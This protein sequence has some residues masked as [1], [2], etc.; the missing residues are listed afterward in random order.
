MRSVA[1]GPALAS[2]AIAVAEQVPAAPEPSLPAGLGARLGRGTALRQILRGLAGGAVLQVGNKLLALASSVVLARLLGVEGFGLFAF[3]VAAGGLLSVVIEW[4]QGPLILRETARAAGDESSGRDERHLPQSIALLCT[5]AAAVVAVLAAALALSDLGLSPLE[6]WALAIAAPLGLFTA[7]VRVLAAS[8]VGARRLL[9]GQAVEQL[10][11]PAVLVAGA[12][13]LSSLQIGSAFLAMGLQTS[14]MIVAVACGIVALRAEIF[15]T[16]ARRP[17]LGLIAR[18]GWPFL[19]IGSALFISQQ[20]D[21]LIIGFVLGTEDVA[22][23]RIG[24]QLAATAIFPT[25]L[26]NTVVS[27]YVVKLVKDGNM[28]GFARLFYGATVLNAGATALALAIF[29]VFGRALLGLLYGEA[30]T[31]ALPIL[32]VLTGGY[33]VNCLFGP[34]GTVLSMTGHER[35]AARVLWAIAIANALLCIVIAPIHGVIGVAT[36]TAS[37]LAAYQIAMR[38]AMRRLLGV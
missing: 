14:A 4:G 8:L 36:V 19:L 26:V 27:P 34:A 7:L 2:G 13:A 29:A 30:F 32:L 21:T 33:V 18:R 3:A 16:Q 38:V 1:T 22:T 37:A 11:A 9:A 17:P 10:I 5:S 35:L 23:Y 25:V 12:V 28:A 15:G 31:A 24:S 20:I 6:R